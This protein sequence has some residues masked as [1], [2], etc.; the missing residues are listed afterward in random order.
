MLS[1]L[2][3]PYL[4]LIRAEKPIGFW[5]LMWPM[6]WGLWLANHGH[7][8]WPILGWM[9]LGCWLMRAAGCALN[10]FADRKIDGLVARTKTRPLASG[11][12]TSKQALGTAVFFALLAYWVVCQLN[13]LTQK[14]AFVALF[15]AC[16]YPFSKRYCDCPQLILG[17]AFA[18]GVPM[19]F[20]ASINH[21]PPHAWALTGIALL[22][23]VAYDTMYAL[24][25]INCDRQH[26]IRSLAILLG[27][28]AIPFCISL[29]GMIL[30]LLAWLG[31]ALALSEVYFCMLILASGLVIFQSHLLQDPIPKNC[32]RAFLSNHWL[33]ALIGLGFFLTHYPA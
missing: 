27:P 18:Q 7:P 23:P 8:P 21:I 3:Q 5:L 6:L 10:D 26:G 19:A 25:D 32:L 22:W 11:A 14:L 17:C 20:A 15:W 13:P 24:A 30:I 33:G 16:I 12:L 2:L 4:A 31:H 1:T 9:L 28:Y 29:Q